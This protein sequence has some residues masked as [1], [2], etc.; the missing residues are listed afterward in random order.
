MLMVSASTVVPEDDVETMDDQ[1]I[2]CDLER[3]NKQCVVNPDLS[4]DQGKEIGEVLNSFH[5]VLSEVPGCTNLIQHK[6]HLTTSEPVRIKPYPVP[7]A[8]RETINNEID[9][10]LKLGVIE[11]SESPYSAPIVLVKKPDGSNRFCV[12][13]RALNKI[14]I[15]DPEPMNNQ[16][17]IFSQLTGDRYFSKLDLSKGYWQIRMRPEDKEKTAF[18]A[19]DRG[20]FHFVRMPFGLVNSGATFVRMMRKLLMGMDHV[21]SYIDDILIHTPTWEQHVQVVTDLLAR[22]REAGL[23]IKPAKCLFGFSSV[24]Y[25][26]HTISYNRVTPLDRN[27][28]KVCDAKRPTT[29]KE[30]QS[31]IGLVTYYSNHVVNFSD[32]IA[33]LTGLVSKCMP[34]ILNWTGIHEACFTRLKELISSKPILQVPDFARPFILQVD[35]S[36]TG[37]G[38]ALLQR[39][40]TE[41]RPVAFTSRKLLPRERCYAIMEKECLAV[42]HSV[43]KFHVYLFGKQFLLQTDHLPLVCMNKNKVANDRIMRW[44]LILQPYSMQIEYIRGRDNVF[45]DFMS[46]YA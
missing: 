16:Q 45:A 40:D 22:L 11:P 18:V 46:R 6:I 31:F 33:P 13:F 26:G 14:T 1:E 38:G 32:V 34:K 15:F 17:D 28:D 5:E 3:S 2:F 12:D 30:L 29:K 23:T 25:V 36:D 7:F 10:M 24:E 35:A 8:V 27:I 19:P 44:A 42:V 9:D 20:C 37:I 39:Y 41:L 43:K 21:H 4:D